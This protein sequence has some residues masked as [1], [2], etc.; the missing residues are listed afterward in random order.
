MDNEYRD[1]GKTYASGCP[2]CGGTMSFDPALGKLK[3]DFCDSVFTTE[4]VE[5]YWAKNSAVQSAQAAAGREGNNE[6]RGDVHFDSNEMRSYSCS[7]CGAE[8]MADQT[9]AVMICPYC[10]NHTIAPSQFSGSIKPDYIIPFSHTKQ[11][12]QESYLNYYRKRY[13]LPKSFK[14]DNHVEEI[15]GVYV[16]FWM[17]SGEVALN[18]NYVAY[19]EATDDEG[20]TYISDRYQV[21]IQG[22]ETFEKVP[23]DASKRMDDNLMDSIEPY[24][25]NEMK[26]FSMVYLPGF[27]AE[28]YDVTEDESHQR[29]KQRIE[30][31][32]HT[33]VTEHIKRNMHHD[34]VEQSN[35]KYQYSGERTTY[36]ML[37]VWMLTTR[38][39]DKSYK[40]AMNGQTGK[41]IGDLPISAPKM[42][43]ILV[44]VF[45]AI[46][47]IFILI[48][49]GDFDVEKIVGM[50]IVA[51]VVDLI[52]FGILYGSMK[53]VH[54]A[55]NASHYTT[56]FNITWQNEQRFG[57]FNSGKLKKKM[58]G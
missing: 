22:N 56:G 12:V 44:P 42:L 28:R 10:G 52:L 4:E 14:S 58:K 39:K 46:V 5:A 41:M 36:A 31:G 8:L 17:F 51:V 11:E 33:D 50:L 30:S 1:P 47:L 43:S 19:D 55:T 45:A 25:L 24:N 38:W 53:P 57:L 13:L 23:A 18:G 27:L 29:A 35:E 21:E 40:F 26:D 32:I 34:G 7:A 6:A 54:R 49:R 20:H 37:P 3:C 2:K 15:Q 48:N 16:P 9:T